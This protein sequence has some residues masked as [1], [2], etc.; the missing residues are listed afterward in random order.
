M[1][2]NTNP[3]P[4]PSATCERLARQIEFIVEIDKLKGIL[5]RSYLVDG[6]R[7]ENSA[8]HSWHL[9]MLAAVLAEHAAE[10]VDVGHVIRMALVHDLVEIDAGDTFLYDEKGN[11]DKHAREC[12]AADRIFGLLP[13]D[14]GAELRTLWDEFEAAETPEARFA[15]SIDRLMPLLHNYHN[16]GRP[17]QEHGITSDRVLVA[18]AGIERGSPTLWAYARQVIEDAVTRG[19]LPTRHEQGT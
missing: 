3:P 15:R 5:R 8:E 19:Y 14:Q 2:S 11:A 12:E 17:W 4:P 16:Q 13:D 7:R 18:C 9:A 6:E 1:P 10:P